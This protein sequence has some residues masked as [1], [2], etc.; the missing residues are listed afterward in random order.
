LWTRALL[1]GH[2]RHAD[3]LPELKRIVVAIDPATRSG[4]GH[5]ETGIIIAALGVDD[6]GYV[7]EDLSGRYTPSEWA[8]HAIAAYYRHKADLIVA[9]TNQGGDMVEYTLRSFDKNLPFKS[10]HASRGKVTRAEPIAALDARG[11]VHHVGLL[12]VLE[13]QMCQFVSGLQ[14]NSPDRVDARV[15][16]LTEL[17]L[18]QRPASSPMIWGG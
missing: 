5:D 1:H 13:D 17:M 2:R 8:S 12:P 16:A 7:L 10:L 11:M 15:W 18:H 3:Q 4:A 14:K 6:H 9:E